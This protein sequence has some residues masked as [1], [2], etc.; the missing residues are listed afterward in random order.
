MQ[1]ATEIRGLT[2]D[3][4][5]PVSGG[6]LQDEISSA[7]DGAEWSKTFHLLV[8]PVPCSTPSEPHNCEGPVW[9]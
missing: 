7:F 1:E 9:G 6:T 3:E 5:R 4:L 2:E 8:Q